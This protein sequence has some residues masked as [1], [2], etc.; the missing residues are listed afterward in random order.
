MEHNVNIMTLGM[1]RND[2]LPPFPVGV[3]TAFSRRRSLR[4]L[5]GHLALAGRLRLS[6][7]RQQPGVG[8]RD[9]GI[10]P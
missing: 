5:P 6:G 7:L 10:H 4:R 3:L 8:A 9:Q 1:P 2:R